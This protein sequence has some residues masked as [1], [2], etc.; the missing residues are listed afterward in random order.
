[1]KTVKFVK[2]NK[3]FNIFNIKSSI[4]NL[5]KYWKILNKILNV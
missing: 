4:E 1:M 3:H 5:S 2:N